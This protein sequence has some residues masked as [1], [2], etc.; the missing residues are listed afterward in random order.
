MSKEDPRKE[1]NFPSATGKRTVRP[2]FKLMKVKQPV[3]MAKAVAECP[4]P[5]T[6]KRKELTVQSN[7]RPMRTPELA[8]KRAV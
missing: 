1:A 5:L 4:E 6:T 3:L 8:E 7:T 2:G